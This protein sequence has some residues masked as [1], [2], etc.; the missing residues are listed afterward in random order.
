LLPL[1]ALI[2]AKAR[3]E[4]SLGRARASLRQER[5]PQAPSGHTKSTKK[6]KLTKVLFPHRSSALVSFASFVFFVSKMDACGA[7]M[8]AG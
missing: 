4:E 2:P 8:L 7:A 3:I 5:A 6:A 1:V